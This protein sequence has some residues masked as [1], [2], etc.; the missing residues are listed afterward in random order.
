MTRAE[1]IADE[2]DRALRGE[3][4]HG[5]SLTDLVEG[6]TADEAVQRPIASAHN[7]WELVLHITSWSNIALRRLVGGQVDPYE[8]EDWP[9]PG[10]ISADNWFAIK[11]EMAESHERLREIVVALSDARLS[12]PVPHS[13]GSV[14]MMLHG[15]AQHAAYHGGQIALLKKAVSIY[16]RRTAL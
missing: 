5:P 13:R 12:S 4:W 8:G 1:E 14:A 9:I 11:T 2:I 6:L 10:E 15:V 16:H 3:A 7:I